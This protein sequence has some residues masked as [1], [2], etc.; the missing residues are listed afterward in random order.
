MPVRNRSAAS[1]TAIAVLAL[2]GALYLRRQAL[3]KKKQEAENASEDKS[4]AT[5]HYQISILGDTFC[6]VVVQGIKNLPEWG[7]DALTDAPIELTPGGSACNSALQLAS[8]LRLFPLESYITPQVVLHTALGDDSFGSFLRE[9]IKAAVQGQYVR[10]STSSSLEEASRKESSGSM[11]N[12]ETANATTGVCICL[13]GSEDRA[14]ITHR[15]V[16]A[17]F[18]GDQLDVSTIYRSQ[19]IHIAGYY[20]CPSLWR[21]LPGLLRDC[22]SRGIFTSLSPQCDASG[23]W[24][25]GLHDTLPH[26]DLFVPNE[27]EALAISRQNGIVDACRYF[28]ESGVKH[29]IVTLGAEGAFASVKEGER[30]RE[31]RQTCP[32]KEIVDTTG[33]GDAFN[34][35]VLYSL[36]TDLVGK[37]AAPGNGTTESWEWGQALRM[38]C[39][40]GGHNVTK[41]GASAPPRDQLEIIDNLK[42]IRCDV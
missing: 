8:L 11:P 25:G 24:E 26:L 20:N 36:L 28:V 27:M 31:M 19:F 10:I 4:H 40:M 16:V 38:G 15:G 14:F 3:K 35:G 17:T 2:V 6:D 37:N 7:T 34:A 9:K 22:Q 23:K 42:E 29:V 5:P 33:A 21:I 1:I 13:S 39:A 12:K 18:S 41:A 32:L 30:R